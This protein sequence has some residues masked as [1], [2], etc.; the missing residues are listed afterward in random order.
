M[1][2]QEPK[3]GK[4]QAKTAAKKKPSVK[5][6][7]GPG[8]AKVTSKKQTAAKKR[9]APKR[10]KASARAAAFS[11]PKRKKTKVSKQPL[12]AFVI[13]LRSIEGEPSPGCNGCGPDDP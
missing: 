11:G 12:C 13:G 8:S 2:K 4:A 10:G 9:A 1:K 7:A 5:K 3:S 6:K